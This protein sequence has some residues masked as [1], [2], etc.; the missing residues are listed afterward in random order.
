[1]KTGYE[2]KF[3]PGARLHPYRD[4]INAFF[5][6]WSIPRWRIGDE[7]RSS[8]PPP[9]RGK[10]VLAKNPRSA[11]LDIRSFPSRHSLPGVKDPRRDRERSRERERE[12]IMEEEDREWGERETRIN[13]SSRCA[14]IVVL[15]SNLRVNAV[16]K[17]Q[18]WGMLAYQ[19]TPFPL[20]F[21]N[22]L[23]K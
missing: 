14:L 16:M 3:L 10:C 17:K 23:R 9:S 20:E 19:T 22:V 21:P 11:T 7:T 18:R 15:C 5:F 2:T 1:M 6:L 13:R 8:F 4:S 12:R